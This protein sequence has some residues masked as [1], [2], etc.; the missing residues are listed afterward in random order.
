M[1]KPLSVLTLSALVAALSTQVAGAPVA[2]AAQHRPARVA[3]VSSSSELRARERTAPI[4]RTTSPTKRPSAP[5]V[6]A[7]PVVRAEAFGAAG[8]GVADDTL[9]LQ[10]ALDSLAPGSTLSLSAGRTYVHTDVLVLRRPGVRLSG[11]GTLLATD[12]ARSAVR[13]AAD[14]VT[15]DGGLVLRLARSTRRWDAFEQMKLRLDG[16]TGTVVR[17]V[18]I[19]GAAAAGIYVGG[20]ARFR[21]E[22]VSVR[23]TRADGIHITGGS[24]DG[25]VL[26]PKIVQSGDDGV[27]VVSYKGDGAITHHI[28]VVSPVV[29]GTTWGRGL[30]VVGGEDIRY[31]DVLVDGSNAAGVYVANEGAPYFTFGTRRVSVVGGQLR[32]SNRNPAI[33]H[34]AVL[35]YSAQAGTEVADTVVEGLSISGTRLAAS[36]NVGVV[37]DGGRVVR[38][39]FRRIALTGPAPHPFHSNVPASSY[40]RTGWTSDGVPLR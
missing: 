16:H 13:V 4:V 36:W 3:E 21:L 12:E 8:D 20:A 9:A 18:T 5:V 22:D 19:D 2:A 35:L 23:S 14:D 7:G 30:S 38:A 27:A 6:P 25:T 1:R 29:L 28:D 34:G 31:R 11:P 10:R 17:G 37:S 15:L 40:S 24:H 32:N 39:A 33:D 26:R